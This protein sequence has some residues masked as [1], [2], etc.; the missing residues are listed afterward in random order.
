MRVAVYTDYAYRRRDGEVYSQRAFSLFVAAVASRLDRVVV[1]G[2]LVPGDGEDARYALGSGVEFVEL[3]FYE[4]LA[5]PRAVLGSMLGSARAF[6]R[7]LDDVDCAWLLGPHPLAFAFA[8]IAR[9][10]GRRVVLGV[11]QDT[12]RYVRSRRPG[13]RGLIFA[14]HVLEKGWRALARILPVVVVGPDLAAAYRRSRSRLEIAVSLVGEGD[15]VAAE[16]PA[17][18]SYDG[19]LR[20]VTVGRL[21]EEKNPLL[22]A[23]IL[24]ELRSDGRDWSLLVAGEGGLRDA[25][26]ARLEELGVAEFAELAGYV[27]IDAGLAEVYRSS[28]AFVHVS[29]TE[30]L[31]QVLLEAFAAGVPVVAT[32]VG[33]VRAAVG[34]CVRLI[35]PGDAAEAARA[36]REVVGDAELR[37]HLVEE[38]FAYVRARTIEAESTR[39]ASFLD[40]PASWAP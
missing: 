31:P 26:Q 8:L 1:L 16:V 21:E 2:R 30:G 15:I 37:G 18:R 19:P 9:V 17:A 14:A 3:P 22:L 40:P 32:D 34:E 11:R 27:P 13:R 38:G 25:L 20:V 7:T 5:E 33:G 39:V 10:R 36:L 35:G 28:H 4:S 24:A 12:P 6:W 29:W 23:D